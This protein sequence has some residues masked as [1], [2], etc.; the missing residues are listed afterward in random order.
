MVLGEALPLLQLCKQRA[1]FHVFQ[2]EI[3]VLDVIEETVKLED[4]FVLAVTL[5]LD[6]F[7]Q[8][9]NHQV[10]FNHL[11]R[12]FLDG[13]DGVGCFVNCLKHAPELSL[14]KRLHQIKVVD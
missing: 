13:I 2:N 1:F 6:L 3:D 4:V 10:R 9:I 7:Q 12:D 14:A 5:N 11:L 8:L